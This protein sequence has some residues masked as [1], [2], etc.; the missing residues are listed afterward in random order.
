MNRKK[1][2]AAL[3]ALALLVTPL[4]AAAQEAEAQLPGLTQELYAQPA[5]E[6]PEDTQDEPTSPEPGP[7]GVI[8]LP[9]EDGV[10]QNMV[11]NNEG[12]SGETVSAF[13]IEPEFLAPANRD[14]EGTLYDQLTARQQ[15]CYNA[16]EGISIDRILGAATASNGYKVITISV[17]QF[18]GMT[19]SGYLT[20]GTFHP[21]G[22]GTATERSFYTDMSVAITAVRYD[23]PEYIWLSQMMSGYRCSVRN[24]V[25]TITSVN[26]QFKMVYGGLEKQ[27]YQ[28]M[29]SNA[30]LVANEIASLS[31]RYSKV[32]VI[33]DVLAAGNSY[34]YAAANGQVSGVEA[35]LC[36]TAYS[37]LIINDRFEPVCDGYA[38]AFKMI[39]DQ[40]RIPCALASSATHMWNNVKMD[41]GEWYNL[42]VTWDDSDDDNIS[43]RYFLIGSQTVPRQKPFYQE[44]DH[45]EEN[46]FNYFRQNVN[47]VT[48]RFPTKNK[49]AYEY[50]GHDYP[51]LRFPDVKR[52]AW[53]YDKVETVAQANIFN[54]NDQ[55]YF[56]PGKDITR[57]EF[58]MAM[59]KMA[60]VNLASYR[61]TRPFSDV[62]A[63]QWYAAAIT[64]VK[65][66][67]LMTGDPGGTFRPSDPISRQEM[68]LVIYNL[69]KGEGYS[70]TASGLT[71]P[72][73]GS[74][75]SWARN[76]VYTCRQLGLVS[77]DDKG[78]FNPR[79]NT[80]RSAAATLLANYLEKGLP[81]PSPTVSNPSG[82]SSGGS[83]PGSTTGS[84]VYWVPNG[85][86]Y[87][88]TRN[89][90]TLHN[91]ST[92]YS[93]TVSQAIR[94]GH[95][96]PCKVCHH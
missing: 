76:A 11:E 21:T 87:H 31:D 51:A 78:Y 83:N 47:P 67:G 43:Y 25:A 36:H 63:S 50:L 96:S 5:L 58:A 73:N 12:L 59:A 60:G 20:G 57:A 10:C 90:A 37:A 13:S 1:L 69:L 29:L 8:R 92:I 61:G 74:I 19:M 52:S 66:K 89:C 42:D 22:S 24:G 77:G 14:P 38:K 2:I 9:E 26:Y 7:D 28:A 18:T 70:T 48:L 45:V 34:N 49:V 65:A 68:C 27:M 15:A 33:H 6:L 53:F 85:R 54:G 81:K 41:D 80:K 35:S 93:G 44:T 75:S 4:T 71:F 95:S 56:Q 32:K 91:S 88:S 30:R 40:A 23:H 3:L 17:P 39:C 72:D 82:G 55:G 16:L 79:G 64:W 84:T 94:T 86:V 62:P 46:P